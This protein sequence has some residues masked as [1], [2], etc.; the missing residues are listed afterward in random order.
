MEPH[1]NVSLP[2]SP[3]PAPTR[4]M[5]EGPPQ[6][7][8]GR[9]EA[10]ASARVIILVAMI[11][12]AALTR[13]IPHPPNFAPMT[14]MALFAAAHFRSRLFAL[15]A[16]L[17]AL[18]ASD[19]G[20]EAFHR[21][22]LMRSWGLYPGMWINYA[23]L[24]LVTVLGFVFIDRKSVGA[25][26]GTT[27]LGSLTFFLVTN[28]GVWAGETLYPKT[29]VGLLICYLEGIPFFG[30]SLLGDVFY[31]TLFFGAFALA[32]RRF[33]ALAPKPAAA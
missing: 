25:V 31:V 30:W 15:V 24:A 26:A 21:L 3:A 11:F 13:L 32:E 10:T 23:A 20:I 7:P 14:A 1:A 4:S 12:L 28:F 19:L 2:S 6:G 8:A 16:P 18:F 29:A 27:L 17:L 5:A 22:G 9:K 33:P